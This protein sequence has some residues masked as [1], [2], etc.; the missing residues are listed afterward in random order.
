MTCY[1][2]IR[3]P[4]SLNT[5]RSHRFELFLLSDGE[6]KIEEKVFSG[7]FPYGLRFKALGD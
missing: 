3:S 4:I 6:K 5:D 1:V 7:L 2:P